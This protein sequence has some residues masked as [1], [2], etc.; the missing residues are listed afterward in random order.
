[1]NTKNELSE[2]ISLHAVCRCVIGLLH[3]KYGN[4]AVNTIK[5]D[6]ASDCEELKKLLENIEQYSFTI[7]FW[8]FEKD[9]ANIK[10]ELK[11]FLEQLTV[12]VKILDA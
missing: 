8:G 11:I 7:Q 12:L 9:F 4:C 6:L 2:M 1:M 5:A 3:D 10:T